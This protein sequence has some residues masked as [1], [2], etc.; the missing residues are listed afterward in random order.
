[1][2]TN[3]TIRADCRA[4]SRSTRHEVLSQ[5]V[6]E[7]SPDVY[8][9]KDTWQIIRCLG[10]HTCGFR[11]RNDDYEMVEEDDEGSYSHQVTTHL[12]PSVLSG[13]RPLSD[14]YFLPRLIQRVYKQ[15][16]S[17]L[18]QRAYV[19]A[20]VGLRA[21]IEAVCN[22][23]KVSG[24]NLE[25]RIDQLYKAGHVSNGDK[26][27]LHAIRFLGNDAAH[28]IKE[29][30]ES[31]IRVALEIVEH[32]LNSVF[33]LEKKAKALDTIAES[34]D[35]FLKILSTSAKTFTGSTAVSLSGLLG[36]KRRLVNQNIDDFETKLKQEIEA[37]SVAFL[38]LSQ[39]PLVGG[40]E[41]QLYEVDS[42]KA[43][44]ADD[45]IPF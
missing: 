42:A 33:I 13:H 45:D 3:K 43:A 22:H 10:C 26:R 7:S 1:M 40:K 31:D 11:H 36:P 21:C 14:T 27:R 39:S 16:L 2:S 17:A 4:C 38:K 19:L 15:T 8:H 25:K 32:L 44:D 28:E 24:T 30:K 5:H 6:D 35:D 29:P 9:E 12:Y 23:L 37:G 20:S 41:V 18:S 34:F